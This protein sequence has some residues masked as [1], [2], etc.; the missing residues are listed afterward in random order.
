MWELDRKQCWMLKNWCLWNVVLEKTPES[1]LD[2]KEIHPV[3]PKGNHW[4]DWCW[5]WNFNT[6]TT[7][8]EELTH[9]KKTLML[10]KILGRRRRGWQRMRWLDDITDLMDMSLSKLKDV[11]GQG[12]LAGWSPSEWTGWISLQSKGPS[13]VFSNTTVQKH[14]FFSAQLSPQSNSHI[15]TWPLEKPEPWLDGP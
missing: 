4:K 12:S 5:G 6:L 11:E 9:W 13:R 15:H 1:P 14:Q 7:W 2:C 8:C 10:G 3:H